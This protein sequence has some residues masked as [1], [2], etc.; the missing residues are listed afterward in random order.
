MFVT[1]SDG[2]PLSPIFLFHS[3]YCKKGA[4]DKW[5]NVFVYD[6]GTTVSQLV[7]IPGTS[8]YSEPQAI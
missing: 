2:F 3:E 7:L 1:H 8:T 5:R 4:E 6:T